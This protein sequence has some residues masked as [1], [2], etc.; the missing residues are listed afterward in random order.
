MALADVL[1]DKT[2]R[3]QNIIMSVVAL[4]VFIGTLM[5]LF[6]SDPKESKKKPGLFDKMATKES[7]ERQ[8]QTSFKGKVA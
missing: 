1:G 3:Q 2:A 8:F 4:G 7:F 6:S 5:L